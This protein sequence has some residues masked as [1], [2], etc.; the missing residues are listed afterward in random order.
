[1]QKHG[2]RARNPVLPEATL[3][4]A[5]SAKASKAAVRNVRNTSSL[6]TSTDRGL[7]VV[8]AQLRF[9]LTSQKSQFVT[10]MSEPLDQLLRHRLFPA[11]DPPEIRPG[12]AKQLRELVPPANLIAKPPQVFERLVHRRGDGIGF[13]AQSLSGAEELHQRRVGDALALAQAGKRVM[14]NLRLFEQFAITDPI[15]L[16]NVENRSRPAQLDRAARRHSR[17]DP[18][19]RR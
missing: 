1:M 6:R 11:Q 17:A 14:G 3:P 2:E 5:L 15:S 18:H 9:L 16:L 13:L 8:V 10:D 12:D 4:G 7:V 19:P